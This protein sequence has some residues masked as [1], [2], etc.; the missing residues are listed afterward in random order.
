MMFFDM[1]LFTQEKKFPS[2]LE[3]FTQKRFNSNRMLLRMPSF[4]M[5]CCVACKNRHFG[6]T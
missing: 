5:L 2:L 6:G 3:Q 1:W 4:G